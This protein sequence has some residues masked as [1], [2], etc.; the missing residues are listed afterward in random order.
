MMRWDNILLLLIVGFIII[1][2]RQLIIVLCQHGP[3]LLD[4]Y[5]RTISPPLRPFIKLAASILVI[6]VLAGFWQSCRRSRSARKGD[7]NGDC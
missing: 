3:A 6:A 4:L 5:A 2:V 1:S 7:K